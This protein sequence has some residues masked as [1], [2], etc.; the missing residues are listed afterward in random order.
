MSFASK[1]APPSPPFSPGLQLSN[2]EGLSLSL[3][4][5]QQGRFE[6]ASLLCPGKVLMTAYSPGLN[7]RAWLSPC[8]AQGECWTSS[9]DSKSWYHW[10]CTNY[11]FPEEARDKQTPVDKC[12]WTLHLSSAL[13]YS[14]AQLLRKGV[15]FTEHRHIPLVCLFFP[16]PKQQ[17]PSVSSQNCKLGGLKT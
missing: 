12:I 13:P 9:A 8:P 11:E 14:Q 5:T 6:G 17:P 1:T 7:C 3:A 4:G 2:Q 10:A 15:P 16:L